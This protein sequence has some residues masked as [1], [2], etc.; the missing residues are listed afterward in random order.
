MCNILWT[1]LYRVSL[2][3]YLYILDV[4]ERLFICMEYR[5]TDIQANH[6]FTLLVTWLQNKCGL[7]H[8]WT[9]HLG[10]RTRTKAFILVNVK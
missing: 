6:M 2:R 4:V 8:N 1:G 5:I 10:Q 9:L 3:C 7:V